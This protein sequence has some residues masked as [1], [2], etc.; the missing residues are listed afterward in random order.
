MHACRHIIDGTRF[1]EVP[2]SLLPGALVLREI[3][4]GA[5]DDDGDADDADDDFDKHSSDSD[6]LTTRVAL[7]LLPVLD[8]AWG[9][10]A[11]KSIV[12]QA[13][14]SSMMQ[15]L[16]HAQDDSALAE[17]GESNTAGQVTRISPLPQ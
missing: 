15:V 5:T 3:P 17:A 4:F 7:F 6:G 2:L 1:V 14:C 8:P 9:L 11:L 13:Q 10:R 12:K 16:A